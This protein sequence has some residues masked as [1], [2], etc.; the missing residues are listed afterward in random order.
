MKLAI[1][2]TQPEATATKLLAE[3]AKDKGHE[4][5]IFNPLEM[6]LYI[7][8][9]H[10]K[11]RLYYQDKENTYRIY[12]NEMDAVITRLGGSLN[13]CLAIVQHIRQNM[14]IFCTQTA[15]GI[16]TASDKLKTSQVLSLH[17][18]HVPKTVYAKE[19]RDVK[20][21]IDLAGGLPVIVKGL[22]GSQG[23]NVV[24][25]ETPLSANSVLESYYKSKTQVI[26]QEYIEP[27]KTG[28]K[29]IRAIVVGNKVVAS[30]QRKAPKGSFKANVS[31]G[32]EAE[33]I[34]LT[35]DQKE[36]CVKA[37]K[38]VGL[39]TSGVDL[40][41]GKDGKNYIIEINGNHGWKIQNVCTDI[42]IAAEYISFVEDNF[43]KGNEQRDLW[44]VHSHIDGL[45]NEVEKQKKE[46]RFVDQQRNEF[47]NDRT[48]LEKEIT[49]LK[50]TLKAK[51]EKIHK[52]YLDLEHADRQL[53]LQQMKV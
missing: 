1:L 43:K 11:D 14:G 5:R 18:I 17:G 27:D 38:A 50:N 9:V 53:M 12:K 3:A 51:E 41:T 44:P 37:S 42:N 23:A 6:Y 32:A 13:H 20:L 16:M 39:D 46:Y 30:M 33:P 7:S 10:K 28:A 25:L 40:M 8:N 48:N 19:P 34:E 26:V 47:L 21:L 15:S 22:T 45:K 49:G 35:E 2:A 4:V 36:L 24:I 52:L 29:D 31:L